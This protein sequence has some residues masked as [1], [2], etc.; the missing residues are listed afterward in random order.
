MCIEQI[1]E[2]GDE[3][4]AV[5]QTEYCGCCE[6]YAEC[7]ARLGEGACVKAEDVGDDAPAEATNA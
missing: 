4:M 2:Q 6:R 5:D 3:K 7:K 1:E